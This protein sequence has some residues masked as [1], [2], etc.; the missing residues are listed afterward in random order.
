[1]VNAS[2]ERRH[3]DVYSAVDLSSLHG[4]DVVYGLGVDIEP[5]PL[6]L[7]H[8]YQLLHPLELLAVHVGP[9]VP[10]HIKSRP[11]RTHRLAHG[12]L[13]QVPVSNPSKGRGG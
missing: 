2:L 5:S 12:I 4:S 10:G 7:R 13:S 11:S 6:V 1:M 8:Y 9:V 3:P